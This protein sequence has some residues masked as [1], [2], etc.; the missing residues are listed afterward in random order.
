M[1]IMYQHQKLMLMDVIW[2][3]LMDQLQVQRKKLK[4]KILGVTCHNSKTLAKNA[5][6]NKADYI[7]FGFFFR[8]KLKPN[9]RKANLKYFEMGE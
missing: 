1:I 3:N 4:G 2:V 8:S 9:A 7:A 6:K 5:I